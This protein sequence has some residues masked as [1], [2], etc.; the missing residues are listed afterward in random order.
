MIEYV[1]LL[2]IQASDKNDNITRIGSLSN[3]ATVL[4]TSVEKA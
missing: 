1:S 4:N 2:S 3:N